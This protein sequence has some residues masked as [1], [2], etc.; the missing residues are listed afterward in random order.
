LVKRNFGEKENPPPKIIRKEKKASKANPGHQP[1]QPEEM[2]TKFQT[3]RK[4][5]NLPI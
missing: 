5:R 1:A 4:G 3:L 2:L